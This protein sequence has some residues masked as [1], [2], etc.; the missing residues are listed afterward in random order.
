[1]NGV[2]ARKLA[3]LYVL[4]AVKWRTPRDALT[5]LDDMEI[6][7]GT[8]LDHAKASYT[9]PEGLNIESWLTSYL[10]IDYEQIVY[11]CRA[12]GVWTEFE[13]AGM[14]WTCVNANYH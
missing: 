9:V 7:A 3:A 6:V 11:D 13:F 4:V 12:E 10:R 14:P 1:M 5:Y 8:A 2:D